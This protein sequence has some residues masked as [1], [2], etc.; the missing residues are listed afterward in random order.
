MLNHM[1]SFPS[2]RYLRAAR[3]RADLS[4]R[5]LAEK[6]GLT[7]SIVAR[8]ERNPNLARV[9]HLAKLLETAGLYLIVVDEEGH[10]IKAESEEESARRDRAGRRFPAH[11]DVRPGTE[12]WWGRSYWSIY[13]RA[14]PEYTFN[15]AR[16]RRD[17]VRALDER[18][19]ERERGG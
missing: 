16:W 15:A 8:I 3:H 17:L 19:R 13:E 5:E 6:A 7:Q 11:F 14:A 18:R 4:Q 2:D 1:L 10:E 12:G 9:E